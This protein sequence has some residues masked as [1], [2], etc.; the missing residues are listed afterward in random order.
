MM[1]LWSAAA[2]RR[3]RDGVALQVK[4]YGCLERQRSKKQSIGTDKS[5]GVLTHAKSGVLPPH[6]KNETV[7]P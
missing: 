5:G 2:R 4:E 6:S 3:S 7:R 1:P